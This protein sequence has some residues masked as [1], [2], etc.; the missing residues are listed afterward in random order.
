[1]SREV[2]DE[3]HVRLSDEP[4]IAEVRGVDG[5]LAFDAPVHRALASGDL[6][7]DGYADV[8]GE[9]FDLADVV[10]PE[11][12]PGE[13]RAPERLTLNFNGERVTVGN[14]AMVDDALYLDIGAGAQRD[15]LLAQ[16]EIWEVSPVC[17]ADAG[18][19][20]EVDG[21]L[22]EVVGPDGDVVKSNHVSD[23]PLIGSSNLKLLR[24]RRPQVSCV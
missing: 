22:V 5:A 1:M 12:E 9:R 6:A 11:T 24:V 13:A 3:V 7:G 17:A 19:F 18:L 21:G 10:A 23:F 14:H 16:A 20:A 8:G 2:L 15:E 4:G